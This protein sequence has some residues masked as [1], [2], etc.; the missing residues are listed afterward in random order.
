MYI[1]KTNNY[2]NISERKVLLHVFDTLSILIGVYITSTFLNVTYI[3]LDSPMTFKWLATFV[4]YFLLFG[5]IFE[6]YNLKVSSSRYLVFQSILITSGTTVFFYVFTPVLTPSLPQDR[7]NILYLFL[8]MVIPLT[9]WRL[10]YSTFIYS[11][12][13]LKK[14]LIIGSSEK[15]ENLITIIRKKSFQTNIVSYISEKKVEKFSEIPFVTIEKADLLALLK[16]T[17]ID[18][19][20]V[21]TS[22]LDMKMDS[23]LNKQ[24]VFLFER[25]VNIKSIENLHEE[26]T[27]SIAKENLNKDLNFE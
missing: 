17:Q 15:V 25:G 12:K 27:E 20:V 23:A 21:S 4:V 19:M 13:F 9:Y 7:I 16:E 24:L 6:L 8:S 2:L 10:I 22:S 3:T 1:K 14:I 26:I 11:P 18:E 5:T